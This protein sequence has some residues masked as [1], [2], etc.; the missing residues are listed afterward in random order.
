MQVIRHHSALRACRCPGRP[1][2]V[3]ML[4][5]VNVGPFLLPT[6]CQQTTNSFERIPLDAHDN[7]AW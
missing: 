7:I 1:H 2:R 4:L 5:H 6:L 3:V